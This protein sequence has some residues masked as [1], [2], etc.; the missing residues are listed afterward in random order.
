MKLHKDL[1][2]DRSL[3]LMWL[4]RLIQNRINN[5][6]LAYFSSA[7][8]IS[9]AVTLFG[10]LLFIKL[11]HVVRIVVNKQHKHSLYLSLLKK[12]ENKHLVQGHMY[13]R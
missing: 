1:F 7:K 12:Q 8:I 3:A 2:S 13:L 4:R 11:E 10:L 5:F 6:F 9:F